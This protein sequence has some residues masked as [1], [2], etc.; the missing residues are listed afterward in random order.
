MCI[1]NI[2]KMKTHASKNEV[3][4]FTWRLV[5]WLKLYSSIK[6]KIKRTTYIETKPK[7]IDLRF[8]IFS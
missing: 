4:V 3:C 5:T 6:D 1:Q 8:F 2:F 7:I